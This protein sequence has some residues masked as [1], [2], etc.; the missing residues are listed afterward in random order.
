MQSQHS[1]ER[2][3]PL[4]CISWY[5]VKKHPHDL[6]SHDDYI[7]HTVY[8]MHDTYEHW[9]WTRQETRTRP[10]WLILSDLISISTFFEFSS[11]Q[12]RFEFNYDREPIGSQFRFE[13][14]CFD[15]AISISKFE[16]QLLSSKIGMIDYKHSTLGFIS[17]DLW[18]MRFESSSRC[19]I[20]HQ[21]EFKFNRRR[22]EHRRHS[23]S[24]VSPNIDH[25]TLSQS[26]VQSITHPSNTNTTGSSIRFEWSYRGSF[27]LKIECPNPSPSSQQ[28]LSIPKPMSVNAM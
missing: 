26:Y 7:Q 20:R 4:D 6:D 2:L 27:W 16:P 22:K 9:P 11:I 1:R 25:R 28:Q 21:F 12:F 10:I 3:W 24:T 18:T 15:L 5:L 19:P 23:T 17:I 13:W 8:T 14:S